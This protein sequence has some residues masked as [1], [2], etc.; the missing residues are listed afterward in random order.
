MTP[1]KQKV[2]DAQMAVGDRVKYPEFK[3]NLISV[4]TRP[5]CRP[6]AECPGGRDCYKGN[7][8]SYLEI[9]EALGKAM[10]DLISQK[11]K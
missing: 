3:G 8:G 5:M 11:P 4:D 1:N 6:L 10:L 2:F 7:A 9:G